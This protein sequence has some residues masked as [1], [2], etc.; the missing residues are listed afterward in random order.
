MEKNRPS[1]GRLCSYKLRAPQWQGGPAS[2][3]NVPLS[4]N[5]P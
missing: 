2:V 4:E 1:T 3:K 5:Q